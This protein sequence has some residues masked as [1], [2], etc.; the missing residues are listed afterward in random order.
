MSLNASSVIKSGT[1]KKN[2]II[3]EEAFGSA[4]PVRNKIKIPKL[5]LHSYV[6]ATLSIGDSGPNSAR[7]QTSRGGRER[8]GSKDFSRKSFKKKRGTKLWTDSSHGAP[9][10]LFGP[11]S[12]EPV[13][14]QN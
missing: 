1:N 2:T 5:P 11:T 3:H 10:E 7:S 4:S 14:V 9:R 8:T 13:I 6:E 12:N